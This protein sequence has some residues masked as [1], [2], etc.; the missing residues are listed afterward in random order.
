[1]TCQRYDRS[2]ADGERVPSTTGPRELD[3]A[4]VAEAIGWCASASPPG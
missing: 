4:L 2:S 1:M 3:A